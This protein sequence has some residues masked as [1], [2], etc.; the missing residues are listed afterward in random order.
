MSRYLLVLFMVFYF[1][2][3]SYSLIIKTEGNI[4]YSDSKIEDMVEDFFDNSEIDFLKPKNQII[5]RDYL[6]YEY[7]KMGFFEVV[8]S[9][10]HNSDK[11]QI[12]VQENKR[13]FLD[14]INIKYSRAD[15]GLVLD[16][17]NVNQLQL[18]KKSPFIE[19]DLIEDLKTIENFYKSKGYLNLKMSKEIRAEDSL[20]V[21]EVNFIVDL[22]V[23]FIF[24]TLKITLKREGENKKGKTS[25]SYLRNLFGL[26]KGDVIKSNTYEDFTSKLRSSKN[27]V[28]VNIKDSILPNQKLFVALHLVEH[29][30]GRFSTGIFWNTEEGAGI[31]SR[32]DY[33]NFFERFYQGNIGAR[34]AHFTQRAFL[35]F[36]DPLFLGSRVIWNNRFLVVWRQNRINQISPFILNFKTTLALS[37]KNY[38]TSSTLEL[39][40]K[41]RIEAQD[42]SVFNANFL[43][44]FNLFNTNVFR[45]RTK[46]S[47]LTLI[48]GNGGSLIDSKNNINIESSR[49]NWL[50]TKN[51]FYFSFS[52]W[53]VLATRLDG[54]LF[55]Q[56]GEDNSR[57][58]FLG[59]NNSIRSSET[60]RICPSIEKS[61]GF[62]FDNIQAA[63]G[64]WSLE[65][66]VKVFYRFKN[67]PKVI[68]NLQLVSFVD[69]ASIWE[70]ALFSKRVN[71][72]DVGIGLRI[73]FFI[74]HLRL[75]Y[76]VESDLS[77]LDFSQSRFILDASQAF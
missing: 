21:V 74:F 18:Q 40:A 12:K 34:V 30:P 28:S 54:G 10:S 25:E 59:G 1:T 41:Q 6:V 44:S 75:D 15:S 65:P 53:I 32:I 62:C 72:T 7:R 68:R 27:F 14:N 42:N 29:I 13:Y 69:I 67:F 63:Y 64:L 46:G 61:T 70:V 2:S 33:T 19:K 76:A 9:V 48:Y 3:L 50:E 52:S 47:N 26:K 57:R 73:P 17:I 39:V 36:T 38:R 23:L 20:G 55:F 35:S 66:R 43:F 16:K 24:D 31:K 8:F 51:S 45:N 60:Q 4:F 71:A 56:N 37:R 5:L 58:F 77:G 49:H 11:V 22:G